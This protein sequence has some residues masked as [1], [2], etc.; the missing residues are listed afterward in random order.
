MSYLDILE[1]AQRIISRFHPHS[2]IVV[3]RPLSFYD[4]TERAN[5]M[6]D[7][8]DPGYFDY[9]ACGNFSEFTTGSRSGVRF[10]AAVFITKQST[11]VGL[12]AEQR[13]RWDEERMHVWGALLIQLRWWQ[14][15]ALAIYD[16][17]VSSVDYAASL[18]ETVGWRAVQLARKVKAR[19]CLQ[20][21]LNPPDRIP[22]IAGEC[23]LRTFN[24]LRAILR[25]PHSLATF[26][27]SEIT[28]IRG[29]TRLFG[30]YRAQLSVQSQFD[31]PQKE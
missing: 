23:Y 29:L 20:V 8:S 27:N 31:Q 28:A 1:E 14:G 7:K 15:K 11:Y 4:G 2:F 30:W 9:R 12:T 13:Q 17:N 22:N 26:V 16:C 21:W 6:Y 24:W 5:W 3:P 19:G 25:D 10:T 18:Q